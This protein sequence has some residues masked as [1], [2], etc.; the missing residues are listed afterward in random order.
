MAK[1]DI[2]S[3]AQKAVFED[4]MHNATNEQREATAIFGAQMYRNGWSDWCGPFFVAGTV[5]GAALIAIPLMVDKAKLH[6][7]KF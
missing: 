7:T 2:I 4:M 6:W 5:F 3:E 1:T